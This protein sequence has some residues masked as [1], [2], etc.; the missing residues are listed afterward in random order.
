MNCISSPDSLVGPHTK[1]HPNDTLFVRLAIRRREYLSPIQSQWLISSMP[2][3]EH[4]VP[5]ETAL[6]TRGQHCFD[7][8]EAHTP[9]LTLL[10]FSGSGRSVW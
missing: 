9:V 8:P 6:V 7:P 4:R 10:I 5:V 2:H 3:P 1:F